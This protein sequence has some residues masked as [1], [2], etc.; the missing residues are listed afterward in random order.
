MPFRYTLSNDMGEG[1][2]GMTCKNNIRPTFFGIA[3]MNFGLGDMNNYTP[4]AVYVH[5]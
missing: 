2:K 4:Y 5:L 3:D 1:W